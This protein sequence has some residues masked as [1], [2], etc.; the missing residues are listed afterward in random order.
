MTLKKSKQIKVGDKIKIIAGN[1]KGFIGTIKSILF[2]KSIVF[3]EELLPRIKYTKNAQN[4][5]SKKVELA[6][7]IHISNVMLWDKEAN[8]VSRIGYKTVNN[9]KKRYFKKSGNLV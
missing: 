5:E 9:E 1:E 2:K 7:P 6:I 4:G 3:I 8:I